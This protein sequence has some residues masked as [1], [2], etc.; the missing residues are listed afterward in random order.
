VALWLFHAPAG[1]AAEKTVR[2]AVDGQQVVGTLE[3]PDGVARPPVILLLHGFESTRDELEIPSVKEGVFRRAARLWSS[4]GLASLRI[5]FRGGG[6][7][8]G[9]FAD[10]T[11]SGQI[12]DAL[13]AIDFLAASDDVDHERISVVGWSMGGAVACAAAGRTVHSLASVSLWAPAT[14]MGS[15]MTFIFGPDVMRKG[16]AGGDKALTA[17][18][19]WGDQV[20][21]R[22]AFFQDL[23]T[24]DPV[25]EI[26]S[27][28]G[29]LLV[30][31]GTN[32]DIVF[33]QPASGKLILD[34]HKGPGELWVQPMDHIFN[35]Q[36]DAA[37]VDRLIAKTGD[38]VQASLK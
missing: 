33:P 24:V 6:D 11:Y 5:D 30:A 25:A 12:R 37:M 26:A 20:T 38:F 3:L 17:K 10:T 21:L 7:S 35:T 36:Q 34:Y 28:R 19:S 9:K 18:L 8:D 15:V 22:P 2:F 27:Y 1:L 14:N 13:A 23:F 32:D 4:R 29:P 16:L 31:V